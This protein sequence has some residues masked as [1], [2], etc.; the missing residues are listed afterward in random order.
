M[1][2]HTFTPQSARKE[3]EF[4]NFENQKCIILL[5]T[6]TRQGR[7]LVGGGRRGYAPPP[8]F[9]N[10]AKDM[11][12]DK[13]ATHFTLG[14]RPCII[15][16]FL[17]QIYLRP[18]QNYPGAPLVFLFITLLFFPKP[19]QFIKLITTGKDIFF[20]IRCWLYVANV[21]LA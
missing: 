11:S 12:L 6:Y 3:A 21:S 20:L 1:A 10:L 9:H 16:F 17:F 14:P 4:N 13:G 7:N 2:L 19:A 18:S 8:A 5:Y 15:S